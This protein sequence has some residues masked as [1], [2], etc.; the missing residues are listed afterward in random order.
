MNASVYLFGFVSITGKF[1]GGFFAPLGLTLGCDL[2]VVFGFFLTG[3]IGV[4]VW[5]GFN[6]FPFC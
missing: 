5:T 1:F 4:G 6:Y 3:F 2:L